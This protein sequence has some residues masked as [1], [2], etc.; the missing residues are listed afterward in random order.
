[1]TKPIKSGEY[2]T[3]QDYTED[4][5]NK[6]SEKLE[7]KK[8]NYIA[9]LD[10]AHKNNSALTPIMSRTASLSNTTCQVNI[11]SSLPDFLSGLGAIAP[12]TQKH[13]IEKDFNCPLFLS[14]QGANE[15]QIIDELASAL[16]SAKGSKENNI[17]FSEILD[18]LNVLEKDDPRL[19]ISI[20]FA[21]RTAILIAAQR[22]G[23]PLESWQVYTLPSTEKDINFW[24]WIEKPSSW[25]PEAQAI[26]SRF[27]QNTFVHAMELAKT[28]KS[29]TV[30]MLKG[31][32]GAGKTSL[33]R[34]NYG[35]NVQGVTGPDSA[36]KMIRQS[37]KEVSHSRSHLQASDA[38]F[39]QFDALIK[40]VEGTV[41]Y[42]SSLSRASDVKEYLLKAEVANKSLKV[43]DITRNDTARSLAVLS[44]SVEGEDP[45]VPLSFILKGAATDRAQRANCMNAI[46]HPQ[47]KGNIP[48]KQKHHYELFTCNKEGTDRRQILTLSSDGM[49]HWI[50]DKDILIEEATSRLHDEGIFFNTDTQQ[51]EAI[52]PEEKWEQ[53]LKEILNQSVGEL[54]NHL[55]TKEQQERYT[56]FKKRMLP[57]ASCTFNSPSSLYAALD[58]SFTECIS[59]EDFVKAFEVVPDVK[60]FIAS[61]ND[62]AEKGQILSY[63]DLPATV[64]LN[65]NA[66]LKGNPWSEKK[67]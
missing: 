44:R 12:L 37:T 18:Q 5:K 64:A 17:Y 41:V 45:R 54:L 61:L 34:Q 52:D 10:K 1:M 11:S 24:K 9:N 38:A 6:K 51:F 47:T 33:I 20:S 46:L 42:D 23:T 59:R 4:T 13:L 66:E 62:K 56:I 8:E 15:N 16:L 60:E 50:P 30:A 65:I 49:V 26:K 2:K 58:K 57:L 7:E 32:F 48:I 28:H 35:D 39:T 53:K 22:S 19:A 43:S 21:L 63:L 31:G 36:K 14:G 40:Q 27:F 29:P 67:R 3:T 55:G 25:I